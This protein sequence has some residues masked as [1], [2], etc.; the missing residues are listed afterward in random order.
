MK[1]VVANMLLE[2]VKHQPVQRMNL[3]YCIAVK[4]KLKASK[5]MAIGKGLY[6]KRV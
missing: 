5:T 1:K 4:A 6:K 2:L 3:K